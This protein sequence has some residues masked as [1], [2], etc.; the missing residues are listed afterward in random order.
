MLWKYSPKHET[1][2]NKHAIRWHSPETG[3]FQNNDS[4]LCTEE[5]EVTIGTDVII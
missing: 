1:D 2:D 4:I 3:R 5:K